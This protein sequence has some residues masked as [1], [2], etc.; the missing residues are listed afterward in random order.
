LNIAPDEVVL[1]LEEYG[2]VSFEAKRDQWKG[3]DPEEYV[4]VVERHHRVDAERRKQKLEMKEEKRIED[5]EK[6]KKKK[7]SKS[8]AKDK[9]RESLAERLKPK[10]GGGKGGEKSESENSDSGSDSDSDSDYDSDEDDDEENND[11]DFIAKDEDARDFQARQARQGGV[12]GAEMKTTVRNLRI[13]EDTPK[14]L[15][16][17]SLDS[18]HYDPKAR[19]MRANPFPNENPEDLAFAGDNFIRCYYNSIIVISLLIFYC[20][21]HQFYFI[22]IS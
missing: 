8:D 3:Y 4:E 19:S 21:F 7:E 5:E 10:N 12:G 6:A 22:F 20:F 16:N 18:A 15:R 17:L 14:Y 1:K 13:R 11:K 2:K 9:K